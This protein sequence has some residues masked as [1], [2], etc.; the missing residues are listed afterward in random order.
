MHTMTHMIVQG[1]QFG[2][3][4]QE[5]EE[6]DAQIAESQPC[7]KCSGLTTVYR[8]KWAKCI[9]CGHKEKLEQE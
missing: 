7:P 8:E 2:A 3:P 4:S 5:A 1:Y 9:K 6:I